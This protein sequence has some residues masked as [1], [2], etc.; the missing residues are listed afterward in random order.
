VRRSRVAELLLSLFATRDVA[1]SIAGD[2]TE[3]SRDNGSWWFWSHA[4]RTTVALCGREIARRPAHLLPVVLFG[5]F[6]YEHATLI[7]DAAWVSSW[8]WIVRVI[9]MGR[10]IAPFLLGLAATLVAE[11]AVT[12]CL[13]VAVIRSSLTILQ[14]HDKPVTWL[15]LTAVLPAFSIV[16]AGV[17]VRRRLAR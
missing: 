13:T 6:S 11:S 14:W 7:T 10:L 16:A 12:G 9:L 8:S 1:A 5:I 2:L 15:V 3:E 4:L 17:F